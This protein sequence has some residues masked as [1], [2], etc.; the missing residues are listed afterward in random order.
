M[1]IQPLGD[2]LAELNGAAWTLAAGR[3]PA[4]TAEHA[5]A[6][7]EASG[8]EG[9]LVAQVAADAW[10]GP[11]PLDESSR[12]QLVAAVAGVDRVVIC[13]HPAAERLRELGRPSAI[14]DIEALV[15]R[16]IVADVLAR[17]SDSQA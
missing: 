7:G 11:Y 12:A 4:L 9:L 10:G 13:D 2:L 5:A 8:R 16:D 14:V 3:F 15:E 6:L 17:H 1:K